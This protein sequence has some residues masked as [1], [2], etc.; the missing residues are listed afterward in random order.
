MYWFLMKYQ[1]IKYQKKKICCEFLFN[2]KI[3]TT[4]VK[5]PI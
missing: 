2:Q 5:F 4:V 3:L 1:K